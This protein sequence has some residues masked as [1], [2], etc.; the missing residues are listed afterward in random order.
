MTDVARG[1][2]EVRHLRAFE[3]VAR[4]QSFTNA[5]DELSITLPALSRTVAQL[6]DALGVTL[7]DRSSRHVSVTRAG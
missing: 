3:S 1:R 2:V 6:E 7:I 4:L 5:A